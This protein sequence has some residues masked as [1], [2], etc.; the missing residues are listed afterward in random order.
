MVENESLL[1][2]GKFVLAGVASLVGAEG[3]VMLASHG[4]GINLQRAEMG[5]FVADGKGQVAR[6]LRAQGVPVLPT[7]RQI[8][9]VE[10]TILNFKKYSLKAE[11]S[12]PC[13][14]STARSYYPMIDNAC[15]T[16]SMHNDIT[17]IYQLEY[18]NRGLTQM[19]Q[20]IPNQ[21]LVY[22]EL[23]GGVVTMGLGI[24]LGI[25]CFEQAFKGLARRSRLTHLRIV[26]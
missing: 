15:R 8:A 21:S 26:K 18:A 22:V 19:E 3:G 7:Q 11:L 16:V 25:V 14:D 17:G 23:A 10:T 6:D 5:A 24:V 20:A 1:S 12:S 9:E 2:R 4:V 13:G